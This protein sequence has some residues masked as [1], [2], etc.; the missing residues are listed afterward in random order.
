[1]ENLTITR[2]VSGL[3]NKEFSCR[4]I[5]SFYLDKIR[6]EDVGI[7][8]YLEVFDDLA[9]KEAEAIDKKLKEDSIDALLAGVPLAI[10]D[11]ILTSGL[12]TSAASRILE[13]Y[14]ASYNATVIERLKNAG[15]IVLGKTNMDEFAMGSSTENSAFGPTL[16]PHDADRVPG[17][18]SGGS[19]AAVA[20]DLAPA[21]L[22]SDTGGS[23]RQPAS[24]SGV[25]GLKPTYGAV[26]RHGLMAMA[27]SLD[28]IG[29]ITK[30]VEDAAIIFEAIRGRDRY[31]A[32]TIETK[33]VRLQKQESLRGLKIGVPKE[34]FGEGLDKDVADKI[35][36]AINNFTKL[37]AD[38]IDVDLPH[39]PYALATYYIVMPA[40]VSANLARFDGIRYGH[41]SR[42]SRNLLEFYEK[43]R[44]EGFGSE[45]KRRIILGTYVLSAGYYEAYY[46]KAQLVR[47]LVKED[48]EKAFRKADILVGPTS[49][50][51]AF[52][53]GQ[54]S[55]NPLQ[56]YL[57][58]IYT[59]AIN[60][61]GV[62]AVSMPSGWVMRDGK[63]LPVGLQ[64]IGKWFDES[65]LLSAAYAFEQANH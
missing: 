12:R 25:V 9:L 44:K 33:T 55:G 60:L 7:H 19:A 41:F 31:D 4:E 21:A 37:G 8:A 28:Q 45:V 51:P 22:G 30:T 40:E 27:S 35:Q 46:G 61:A 3:K 63:K 11:N 15:S 59:V 64:M 2:I 39:A 56:M 6:R 62:P 24:F 32:T 23:I 5:V 13:S 17:G 26:S 20:A 43:S 10:K 38:V 16:N 48:F 47:A 18:S 34:Y 42:D 52:R 1:M 50:T 49:P 14:T 36:G 65:A 29:P 58:D 54:N 53:L 57:A